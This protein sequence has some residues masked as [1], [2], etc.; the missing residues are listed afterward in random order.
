MGFREYPFQKP[1]LAC[2]WLWNTLVIENVLKKFKL[3]N[4]GHGYLAWALGNIHSKNLS[5][6]VCGNGIP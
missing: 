5:Y 1:R 6:L 3:P 2:P 4:I